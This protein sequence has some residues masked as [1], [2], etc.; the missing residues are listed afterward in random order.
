M[1]LINYLI[2][3]I[4]IIC[5]A[6]C[7]KDPLSPIY[8]DWE[9]PP[10]PAPADPYI[11][12]I[13]KIQGN[14]FVGTTKGIYKTTDEGQKWNLMN[15]G[16]PTFNIKIEDA[17]NE[18]GVYT[19]HTDM[20]NPNSYSNYLYIS[21]DFGNSW[22]KEI[23][24]NESEYN[25]EAGSIKAKDNYIYVTGTL[26]KES[27]GLRKQGIIRTTDEGK[28]WQIV[29]HKDYINCCPST[30]PVVFNSSGIVFALGSP[31]LRSI[32]NGLTWDTISN[33]VSV[34]IINAEIT[35]DDKIY[36]LI[37]EYTDPENPERNLYVSMDLGLSWILL[38][39]KIN[40]FSVTSNCEIFISEYYE[41]LYKSTDN[42]NSWE[43]LNSI[44]GEIFIDNNDEIYVWSSDGT[45]QKSKDYGKY[46]YRVKSPFNN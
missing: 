29:Y 35:T 28:T 44:S 30:F 32:D 15:N 16:V 36:I 6:K 9:P 23:Y 21:N 33:I 31:I 1:R 22:A 14:L 18:G 8:S 20:T 5:I 10:P 46:W 17:T 39:K 11:N 38:K 45:I 25:L 3:V 40:S 13:N 34:E 37:Y 43:H 41:G 27:E 24:I 42:G 2:L 26:I 4:L 19:L 12:S 7:S